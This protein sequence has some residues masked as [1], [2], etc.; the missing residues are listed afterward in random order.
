MERGRK[1][2]VR[3][4]SPI[5][6]ALRNSGPRHRRRTQGETSTGSLG[7]PQP[8]KTPRANESPP[9]PFRLF[10][11]RFDRFKNEMTCVVCPL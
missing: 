11:N 7:D 3:F 8:K 5:A 1:L 10:L 4:P 2:K 9:R 6:E